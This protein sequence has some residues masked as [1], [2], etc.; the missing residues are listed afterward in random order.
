MLFD[1]P[2][3]GIWEMTAVEQELSVIS[4]SG[5]QSPC[6]FSLDRIMLKRNPQL[7]IGDTFR[8]MKYI[9]DDLTDA[10]FCMQFNG[11]VSRRMS[12]RMDQLQ[13][14]KQFGVFCQQL[15]KRPDSGENVK[16]RRR[17]RLFCVQPFCFTEQMNSVWKSG[18]SVF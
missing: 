2:E 14:G 18:L 8:N 11:Q 7:R 1:Q 12:G 9:I 3:A 15:Q 4:L 17:R 5:Q 13:S 6:L 10:V 16:L